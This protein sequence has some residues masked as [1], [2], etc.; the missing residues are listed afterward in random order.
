M[1]RKCSL[2][3]LMICGLFSSVAQAD[4]HKVDWILSALSFSAIANTT[5]S[6]VRLDISS[7]DRF[8]PANG[9]LYSTSASAPIL[10]VSG[11]CMYLPNSN[12]KCNISF[13][14]G[15]LVIDVS[16]SLSGTYTVVNQSGVTSHSGTVMY[17]GIIQ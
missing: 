9:A 2:I 3:V 16:P 7:G 13:I 17:T 15:S 11:T 4:V 1:L 5:Y 6:S 8:F 12:V 14:Y 10:P